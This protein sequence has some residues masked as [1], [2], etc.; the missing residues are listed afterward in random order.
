MNS[1]LTDEVATILPLLNHS[2]VSRIIRSGVWAY[3][4]KR[5]GLPPSLPPIDEI[6]TQPLA[7]LQLDN[8]NEFHGLISRFFSLPETFS[9][10]AS[11]IFG[12]YAARILGLWLESSREIT[13]FTSGSTGIAKPNRHSEEM[14]G[15]EALEVSTFFKADRVVV[16][17]PLMH[18]YGFIFGLLLA[19][20][21][22]V[23]LVEVPPLST[24]IMARLK[25][26]DLLVG[27]PLLFSGIVTAAP[28]Q[29]TALTA[30]APCSDDL[31]EF[32]GKNIFAKV[33][34]IYGTSETG[35]IA[36]RN[37]PGPFQLLKFWQKLDNEHLVRVLPDGE[38][39]IEYMAPDYIQWYD[40][41]SLAPVGRRDEAVQVG[42]VNVYPQRIASIISKHPAVAECVVRLMGAEEGGRLKVFIVLAAH[43]NQAVIYRELRSFFNEHL[44]PPERPGQVT[45]GAA[46]P[47]TISGKPADWKM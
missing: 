13:F 18:S 26:G 7:Q 1:R 9:A 2:D 46:L 4:T 47:R 10:Q 31:F 22:H 5:H 43:H 38:R 36:V 23:E 39:V 20:M 42:G 15:Q 21:L 8:L 25:A 44:S 16:S 29:V 17:V 41:R 6:L 19:K 37:S 40:E 12:D 33:V 3:L 32:L 34:E 30:T 28:P 14:L 45:F 11:D 35:A 27:F 24:I